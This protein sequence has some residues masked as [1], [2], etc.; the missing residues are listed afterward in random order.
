MDFISGSFLLFLL[1]TLIVYYSI[2][3]KGQWIWLLLS[4]MFFYCFSSPKLVVF[5]FVSVV[6]SYVWAR[7][8]SKSK[9]LFALVLL[10]NAGLLLGLKV[11]SSGSVIASYLKIDRFAFLLPVGISFYTLQIIAYMSDVYKGKIEPEKSFFKYMLFVTY[12]PQIIQ[13]PIPRYEQLGKQ[14]FAPHKFDYAM[15]VGGFELMIWGYFQKLVIADRANILVNRLY[16]EYETYTG[17]YVVVAVLLYSLQL[18]ADFNGCVCIVKGAS[19][20]FG[21]RLV[22]N[23]DRP[24]FSGSIQ[25]LWRRW[26]MTLGGWLRDYVY[27]PLGG[28]RKGKLR[29][30]INIVIVFLVSGIWHGI[31]GTFLLWGILQGL[32]QILGDLLM[33]VRNFFVRIFR[34]NRDAFSHKL[35][36][37]LCTFAMI[38]FSW[39]F[40]RASTVTQSFAM[41]KNMFTTFNPWI[42]WDQ[43]LYMLGL[44]AKNVW[45]LL[46]GAVT[47]FVVEILQA[48]MSIREQFAKQG[49][50]F[51]Y[52]IL[53]LAIFSIL[54]FGIYG[55]GYDAAQFIYGGF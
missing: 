36:K 10:F 48:K 14:L 18:Y 43:S 22:D 50:V 17:M 32:Y 53:Y 7:F 26:H 5:V 27:I 23:F 16:G 37:A 40:F 24:Y 39:L 8:F 47:L 3:K 25:E 54:I 52:I 15:F 20:M 9:V 21:I 31:G 4:G 33:P 49:I 29:K 51:R 19:E 55:P 12:F 1:I 30:Y 28:N 35:F 46:F 34:V 45:M 42:L 2:P 41:I 44:D 13:G 6:T 38:N 11:A